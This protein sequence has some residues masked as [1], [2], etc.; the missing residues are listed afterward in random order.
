M[1]TNSKHAG[2]AIVQRLLRSSKLNC[3]Q[4]YTLVRC[5]LQSVPLLM[6]M[7]APHY[8]GKEEL[9]LNLVKVLLKYGA[10]VNQQD[11]QVR[12]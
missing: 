4:F 1:Y 11:P 7:T 9:R 5:L 8:N 6:A 3:I 2:T 10:Q 12:L